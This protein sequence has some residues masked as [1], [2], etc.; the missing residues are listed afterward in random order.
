MTAFHEGSIPK[1]L[2]DL[3]PDIDLDESLL[4]AQKCTLL[5]LLDI[6][7]SHLSLFLY[8]AVW[9]SPENRRNFFEK[10]AK[11]NGFDPLDPELWYSQTKENILAAVSY[12]HYFSYAN[13][14][15]YCEAK[16]NLV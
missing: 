16:Y 8:L 2:I 3:F 4:R 10:Y 11:Q 6:I 15:V 9:K 14:H 5:P 13:L 7:I 1:A 12:I